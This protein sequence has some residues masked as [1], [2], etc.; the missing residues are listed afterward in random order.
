MINMGITIIDSLEAM[1]CDEAPGVSCGRHNKIN[2]ED[3]IDKDLQR[4]VMIMIL[5]VITRLQV[6]KDLLLGE[7]F[8]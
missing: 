8:N 3:Y 1:T 7:A 4:R 2:K 5:P 6:S